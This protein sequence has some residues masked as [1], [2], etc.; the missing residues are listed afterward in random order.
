MLLK[1]YEVAGNA[2]D[3]FL[4]NKLG[5]KVFEG[6]HGYNTIDKLP[7]WRLRSKV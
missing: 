7:R 3:L 1:K 4:K 6:L 5:L 2:V